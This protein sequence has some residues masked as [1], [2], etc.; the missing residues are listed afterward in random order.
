M[1]TEADRVVRWLEELIAGYEF[2]VIGLARRANR[3]PYPLPTEPGALGNIL[4]T[5]AIG[6]LIE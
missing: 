1:M 2:D 6:Y 4:E 3:P 5:T